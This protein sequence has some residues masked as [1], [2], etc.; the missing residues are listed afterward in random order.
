ML[1]AQVALEKRAELRD[2][3]EQGIG[4]RSEEGWRQELWFDS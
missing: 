2:R 4:H 1:V 3:G